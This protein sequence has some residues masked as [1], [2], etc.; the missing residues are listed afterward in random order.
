MLLASLAA[1][2]CSFSHGAA[3][4]SGCPGIDDR[5]RRAGRRARRWR[6][7]CRRRRTSAPALWTVHVP[8]LDRPPASRS[9]A[10]IDTEPRVDSMTTAM[11]ADTTQPDAASS[12]ARRSNERHRR[13]ARPRPL[14]LVATDD[15]R[16]SAGHDVDA[17]TA[18]SRRPG[19][20][21]VGLRRADLAA[22]RPADA[23]AAAVP[24]AR[25]SRPGG[26]GGTGD[27]AQAARASH[28]PRRS[29]S[30]SRRLSWL[31]PAAPA[32]R[33]RPGAG[34]SGGGAIYA[35]RG[36]HDHDHLREHRQCVGRRRRRR[37]PRRAAAAAAAR[38]A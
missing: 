11:W 13:R 7:G 29:R 19:R 5:P 16:R 37:R 22:R 4:A 8:T 15:D 10:T 21:L 2:G 36:Q 34:R 1:G 18:T 12:S 25:T 3:E 6:A 30:H 33:D 17:A 26:S 23:E 14:V 38:A 28:R 31:A 24:A 35:R 20:G 27:S 9:P 32:R